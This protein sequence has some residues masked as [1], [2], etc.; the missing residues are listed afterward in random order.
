MPSRLEDVPA[1]LRYNASRL[2]FRVL[3]L[4]DMLAEHLEHRAALEAVARETGIRLVDLPPGL[5]DAE[6][7]AFIREHLA[8]DL[9]AHGAGKHDPDT[10][11]TCQLER[12]PPQE[13][14]T[15]PLA[16][17][18][19]RLAASMLNAALTPARCP[20]C[21]ARFRHPSEMAQHVRDTGDNTGRERPAHAC[22]VL[23][24]MRGGE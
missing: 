18:A 20:H 5:T 21:G 13:A 23:W 8:G 16:A 22:P 3:F 12:T 24:R 15:R 17:D 19:G 4:A 6:R 7:D 14:A 11:P 10:C 9:E 1:W 2:S